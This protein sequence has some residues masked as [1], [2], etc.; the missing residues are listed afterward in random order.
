[1]VLRINQIQNTDCINEVNNINGANT[2]MFTCKMV[3]L[4]L[5]VHGNFGIP[6]IAEE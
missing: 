3:E 2:S 6:L 1:M 4:I 5:P